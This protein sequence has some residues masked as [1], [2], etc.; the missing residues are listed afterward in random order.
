[1]EDGGNREKTTD[2]LS[3]TPRHVHGVI[4][5]T[6]ISEVA[7]NAAC[8]STFFLFFLVF[9]LMRVRRTRIFPATIFFFF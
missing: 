6:F 9:F 4:D 7:S 8:L 5:I 3:K 1:M 2:A